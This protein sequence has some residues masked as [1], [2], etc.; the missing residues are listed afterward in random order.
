MKGFKRF[1]S[2]AVALSVACVG[3]LQTA[4]SSDVVSSIAV[5]SEASVKSEAVIYAE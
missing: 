4:G 3:L 5:S 1:C 2:A